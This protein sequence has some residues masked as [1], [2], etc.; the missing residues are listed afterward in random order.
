VV[1]AAKTS[2][3]PKRR[4]LRLDFRAYPMR[5][6]HFVFRDGELCFGAQP[7][8]A[9]TEDE[10]AFAAECDGKTL[11][12]DL[13][14][15]YPGATGFAA[16]APYLTWFPKPIGQ[17]N[18]QSGGEHWLVIAPHPD[19]AELSMGGTLL[20]RPPDTRV[21]QAVCF[22]Y[23]VHTIFPA[24]FASPAEVS[25]IRQDEGALA[26]LASGAEAEFFGY[27]EF[28]LRETILGENHLLDNE[29]VIKAALKL[30]IIASIDRAAPT[31]VFAPA[32]IGNHPD[33][34]MI[35]DIIVEL[36]DEDRFPTITFHLYEDFPYCASY[37]AVD[38]FLSRFEHS[39]LDV[40]TWHNPITDVLSEKTAVADIYR[41]QF[42]RSLDTHLVAVAER[43]AL[44]GPRDESTAAER[45]WTLG[46]YSL[47]GGAA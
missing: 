32:S 41:T 23:A 13:M 2:K 10:A 34:R 18:S 4:S 22:S 5:L 35:F 33:H 17:E 30:R 47:A 20:N 26:A 42:R 46:L 15:R 37:Q 36:V 40:K 12:R 19:D 1:E 3:T 14:A 28:K 6:P 38:D 27:P 11:F 45:F 9:A 29:V 24:S 8:R 16:S 44:T 25:A 21:T 39:Y 43:V 31:Q 7:L